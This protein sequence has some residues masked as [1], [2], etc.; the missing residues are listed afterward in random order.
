MGRRRQETGWL[1]QR[2]GGSNPKGRRARPHRP[3]QPMIRGPL[4]SRL[5]IRA[6]TP[7]LMG[8]AIRMEMRTGDAM[9]MASK[10]RE[11]GMTRAMMAGAMLTVMR[12]TTMTGIPPATTMIKATLT[13]HGAIQATMPRPTTIAGITTMILSRMKT[14]MRQETTKTPAGVPTMETTTQNKRLIGVLATRMTTHKTIAGVSTLTTRINR[15]T[16]GASGITKQTTL[17]GAPS[18]QN[19]KQ[20]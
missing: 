17:L 20:K 12:R 4:I 16:A 7:L 18:R 6:R 5:T 19:P 11:P 9:G 1:R 2:R 3:R 13:A 10:C 15:M 8:R 14:G